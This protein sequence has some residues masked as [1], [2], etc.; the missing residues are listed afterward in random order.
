MPRYHHY[1]PRD[2]PFLTAPQKDAK[3]LELYRLGWSY[4]RIARAV[5]YRSPASV[6]RALER[7][8]EGRPARDPARLKPL[9]A[10]G[11]PQRRQ[12]R[13]KRHRRSSRVSRSVLS[14]L[15]RLGA[16]LTRP[17]RAPQG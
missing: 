11:S 14:L 9:L 13:Q 1:A 17:R 6:T 8:K 3:V 2:A 5:G 15:S 4:S 7:I 12:R 16:R 10:G